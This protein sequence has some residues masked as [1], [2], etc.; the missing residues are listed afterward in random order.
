MPTL[1]ILSFYPTPPTVFILP[2][3]PFLSYRTLPTVFILPYPTHRFYPTLPIQS[4]LN[5]NQCGLTYALTAGCW[6]GLRI[7]EHHFHLHE[8]IQS[9]RISREAGLYTNGTCN[10]AL[11]PFSAA[12]C[13]PVSARALQGAD[14]R[15]PPLCMACAADERDSLSRQA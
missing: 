15:H 13:V 5:A 12:A 8:H 3:P 10:F 14:G 1:P 2:Y 11:L 4:F 6:W 7:S 9:W